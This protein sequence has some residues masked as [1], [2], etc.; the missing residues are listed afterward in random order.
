MKTSLTIIDLYASARE[1]RG[2]VGRR[3]E[4]IYTIPSGYLFKFS[5]GAY[6]LINEARASL[7]GVLGE[8]D[9]R[10][11]ETLRGLIRDDKLT[12]VE[13]PRFDKTLYLKFG[14]VTLIAELL[15]PFNLIAVRDGKI[16]WVDRYYRGKDREVK[17][18]VPYTPPPMPYIDP[19]ARGDEALEALRR[20]ADVRKSLARDLGLGPEVAE[21]VY[22]RA[23]GDVD[24]A[25]RA[26]KGLVEEVTNGP[27]S[28]T[29]YFSDGSPVTVTPVRYV[30]IKA[31]VEEKHDTFW[32]ALDRYFGDLE[33]KKA[34]E[35]KTAEL[36]AK[37][38]RLEQ[39]LAKLRGEIEEY[40]KRG[41]ELYSLARFVLSLKYELEELL[42]ALTSNR[43]VETSIRIVDVN[44]ANKE[45]VL[46]HSGVKFKLR[47]DRPVGRQIE[48]L[49]EEAK[50]YTRKAHK[51]EETYRKLEEELKRITD[52]SA[53]VERAIAERM[54]KTAERAWFEKYR[55][56]LAL[57][58]TPALGGRD[59]SQNESLVRKY[60][61]EDYLFF[62]ADVPGA[63]A[64]V[65][66]PTGD[67]M[68]IL[69]IAQFAASYSRAWKIGV[70]ALDVFY[71]LGGQVSKQAP[72]GEYLAR[73]SFMIYGSRN[74]VRHVRLE[75]AVGIRDDGGI[76]RVVAAPPR[77]I[78]LLAE[79]YAVLTPGTV[80]KS[81]TAKELARRWKAEALIDEI[82]A[83]LP[84]PSSV[85]E[86]GSG[87]PISWDEI[88]AAFSAW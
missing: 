30:S 85:Q 34:V 6:L 66:K 18:G 45:V 14:G 36:K 55:W 57:G 31:D 67:E 3:V 10:G 56:L 17:V 68:E 84:G 2:L 40:R 69:E 49:F 74:Y 8:R 58:R 73:G 22:A 5:G 59:A 41:E 24:E 25:L 81:K 12:G 80:E 28:P 39:S 42:Q 51:A 61:K 46:E 13:V 53:E 60:L 4:N 52:E 29:V 87:T 37:K 27:L 82:I 50:E 9:Y 26:L 54:R 38:A 16:V 32:K 78:T 35:A 47:L 11:A 63:S 64:V 86:W 19:L 71:V 23:S 15:R 77:S 62:H 1:I 75:L 48:A 76:K 79:R 65:A 20:S 44:R 88:K 83:A 70:H 7:T 33:L 43:E 72:A 21:E